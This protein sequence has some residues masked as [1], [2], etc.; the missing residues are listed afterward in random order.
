MKYLRALKG[1]GS[2]FFVS[3][4]IAVIQ[5]Y[6]E[7][8]LN[9]FRIDIKPSESLSPS[10]YLLFSTAAYTLLI[11]FLLLL[12]LLIKVRISATKMGEL[13]LRLPIIFQNRTIFKQKSKRFLK[14]EILIGLISL[15]LTYFILK[16]LEN[17]AANQ[18][19]WQKISELTLLSTSALAFIIHVTI[20]LTQFFRVTE[21]REDGILNHIGSYKWQHIFD[22]E[23]L[24]EGK[25]YLEPLGL[26]Y[27]VSKGF[28]A[29][30]I[31]YLRPKTW[32][33]KCRLVDLVGEAPIFLTVKNRVEV[34]Q[35]LSSKLPK[36]SEEYISNTLRFHEC[37]IE[38]F[39]ESTSTIINPAG[40][41]HISSAITWQTIVACQWK[42]PKTTDIW[43][44]R[45]LSLNFRK[46][47]HILRVRW[48]DNQGM[49][50]TEIPVPEALMPQVHAQ[51]LKYLPENVQVDPPFIRQQN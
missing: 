14:L 20:L 27:K 47:Y 46:R 13:R 7:V 9:F 2:A 39:L 45:F 11:P 41:F 32:A 24:S 10:T 37:G 50:W 17:L 23:W 19:P 1:L 6:G 18:M 33:L 21:I 51:L 38:L 43:M 3:L 22:Y 49:K 44:S 30:K 8:C 36:L 40:I 4:T 28:T 35:I 29:L 15:P 42:D 25:P 16:F 26:K 34:E 12:V 5:A 48:S 31:R